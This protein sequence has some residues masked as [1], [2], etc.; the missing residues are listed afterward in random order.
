MSKKVRNLYWRCSVTGVI[1]GL[2]LHV[3][4][5]NAQYSMGMTGG[6]TVPTADMQADGTFMAGGNYLPKEM[7]PA[8]WD[9]NTGNYFLNLTF[10][11]FAELAYRCT[12]LRGEF[13]N[14]N[15]LQQDRSVGIRLRPLKEGRY[16]PSLVVGTN[17][18]F[19]TGKL[20]A[21]EQY[22]GENRYFSSV[23]A[24][25]TKHVALN[26]HDFG[27]S[28]GANVYTKEDAKRKGV[29]GNINYTPAFLK[30]VSLIAEYDSE[31]FN[32]GV[33]G[34]LFNHFSLYAFCYDLNVVSGGIRYEFILL[35][36]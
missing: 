9:Y 21:L 12:F 3:N 23:Y 18:A 32:F 19:T 10:L 7:M 15:K 1:C 6:W 29:F 24:V 25:V 31:V 2:W 8:T 27:F 13:L 28:I 26:D 16:W 20:N 5:V 11:P 35:T 30:Q 36:K 33:S 34:R 22:E 14:G 17:D 4:P